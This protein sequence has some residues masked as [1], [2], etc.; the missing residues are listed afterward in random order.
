MPSTN[1]IT[2]TDMDV[3]FLVPEAISVRGSSFGSYIETLQTI[4]KLPLTK[5][6]IYYFDDIWDFSSFCTLNINKSNLR[7]HFEN[8]AEPFRN[9]SKNYILVKLLDNKNKIQSINSSHDE[10]RRFLNYAHKCHFYKVEDITRSCIK[11]YLESV[12]KNKSVSS[13]RRAKNVLKDFYMLYS[14]NFSDITTPGILQ[15]FEHD[16][17]KSYIA[18]KNNNKTKNIP[19]AYFDNFLSAIVKV[20]N[21]ETMDIVWRGV[22]CVYVILSQIGL[23]IGEILGLTTDS[24]KPVTLFDGSQANY[25]EYLTWKRENGNNTATKEKTYINQLSRR[26]YD[27]LSEIFADKRV[28]LDMQYLYMGDNNQNRVEHFPLECEKFQ[29]TAFNFFIELDR[30]GYLKTV[31]LPD[32]TNP[33]IHRF[34]SVH[35][36]NKYVDYNDGNGKIRV[37]SLTFPDTQQFRFHCCSELYRKGVPMKYVQR[38]MSHLTSSMVS[39]HIYPEKTPQEN[40]EFAVDTLKELLSGE[41][42]ILGSDKGMMDRLSKYVEEQHPVRTAEDL[43]E[44]CRELALTIPIRQKS[45]G[46]C[47]KSSLMRECSHDAATNDFYCAYGV[48]PNIVHFYY[49]ADVSHAKCKEISSFIYINKI[50]EQ[51]L[52]KER[53]D[54]IGRAEK[55]VYPKQLQKNINMLYTITTTQL[56]PELDDLERAIKEFGVDTVYQKHPDIQEIAENIEEIR[57][58]AN[59]WKSLKKL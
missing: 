50:R 8:V 46:V 45:G 7:F 38:F 12:R 36:R 58:E 3:D 6:D 21:D 20:M 33:D 48:C 14:I 40:M 10:I 19:S 31:N 44:I 51:E 42:Q 27:I 22:A 17:Y 11:N 43:N 18:H 30:I 53:G 41:V 9:D 34:T 56:L 49:M 26:A 39:Y 2:L 57:K 1:Y 59:E 25:L 29:K 4:N 23:R 35:S 52:L 5:G 55:L 16:D 24:L 28:A 13:L 54:S 15:L 37:N 32:T 47:I